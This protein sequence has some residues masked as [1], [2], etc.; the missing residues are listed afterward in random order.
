MKLSSDLPLDQLH[1]VQAQIDILRD[2]WGRRW[3]G[4]VIAW[5]AALVL[6]LVLLQIPDRYEARSRVRVDTETMIKPLLQGL[7]VQPDIDQ[8]VAMLARTLINRSN[9][10]QLISSTGIANDLA[11]PEEREKMIDQL[12][13]GIKVNVTGGKNLYDISYRDTDGQRAQRIVEQLVAIFVAS[14]AGN[15]RHDTDEARK[16][17]DEQI[18]VYE[19]KL[20][21]SENKLKNFKIRNLNVTGGLATSASQDYFTKI[22]ET[23]QTLTGLRI[24]ISAAERARD[25]LQRQL[26]KEEAA[27]SAGIASAIEV[28]ELDSRIGAL[29]KQLDE[30]RRHYTDEYPDV[31]AAQKLLTQLETERRQDLEHRSTVTS[32]PASGAPDTAVQQITVKLAD[33]DATLSSLRGRFEAQNARLAELR[34][35]AGRMPQM[36]SELAQL[37]RDY[38]VIKKNYEQLVQRRESASISGD[39]DADARL[40]EFRV[41]EPARLDPKPVSPSRSVLVPLAMLLS[42]GV[43]AAACAWIVRLFPAFRSSRDL[44]RVGGRPVLGSISLLVDGAT[45]AQEKRQNMLFA[46]S[47]GGLVVLYGAW[48][49]ILYVQQL[50]IR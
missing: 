37:N 50:Q 4:V 2:M 40:A 9:I 3:I 32:V 12:T 13:R 21:E 18:A 36:E 5:V 43:G 17:I 28:Q 14:G 24:E 27:R 44:R 29:R 46:A 42:L 31:Q 19:K 10:E 39:V 49:L 8:M 47:V 15:K 16:F 11:T 1:G 25:T 41:I 38:D 23:Q 6:A 20:E 48:A 30:L 7:T 35:M 26:A 22:S 33:A 34:A 45:L